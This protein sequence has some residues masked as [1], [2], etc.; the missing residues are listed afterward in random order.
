ML[1]YQNF[2]KGIAVQG[3]WYLRRRRSH[4][5]IEYDKLSDVA[6][7]W[8]QWRHVLLLFLGNFDRLWTGLWLFKWRTRENNNATLVWKKIS[9]QDVIKTTNNHVQLSA[10]ETSIST[11]AIQSIVLL[12]V[13]INNFQ[14]VI[15]L[16]HSQ[17]S[18]ASS[19]PWVISDKARKWLDSGQKKGFS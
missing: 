15:F 17:K 19:R 13:F 1:S 5:K 7:T 9:R 2:A 18:K 6:K 11:P 8:V 3:I 12:M 14:D 4:E 16:T 10:T